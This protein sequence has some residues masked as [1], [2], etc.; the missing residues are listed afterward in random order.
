MI[1]SIIYSFFISLIS[2]TLFHCLI[3]FFLYQLLYSNTS[4][5]SFNL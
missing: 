2:V 4:F 3:N 1:F 5:F